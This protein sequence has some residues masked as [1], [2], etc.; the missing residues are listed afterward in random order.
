MDYDQ[1]IISVD[2]AKFFYE[3]SSAGKNSP[4]NH[5]FVVDWDKYEDND[6]Y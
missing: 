3:F 5:F 2:N 6:E 1:C 4:I